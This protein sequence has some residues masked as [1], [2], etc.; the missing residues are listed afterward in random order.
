MSKIWID[1]PYCNGEGYTEVTG[2]YAETLRIL[3]RRR[4]PVVANRDA[5]LFGCKPT[6]LNN[7]LAWLESKGLARSERHGSARRF[8]AT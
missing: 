4:G 2:V 1:C 7:R 3:R 5:K 8:W 6:A